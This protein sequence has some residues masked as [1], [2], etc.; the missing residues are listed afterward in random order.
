MDQIRRQERI[1][2]A[3]AVKK[4]DERESVGEQEQKE[5]E[6][7]GNEAE[8]KNTI[9]LDKKGFLAFIAMVLNCALE[10]PRKSERIKMVLDAARRFLNV[11]E[12]SGEELDDMLREGCAPPQS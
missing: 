6:E 11:G 3:Q 12:I 7:R 10:I 1:S 2:Y 9:C 5:V 8:K 4:L